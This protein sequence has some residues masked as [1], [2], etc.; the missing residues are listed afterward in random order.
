MG[1]IQIDFVVLMLFAFPFITKAEIYIVT[2]EGDPV[3]SYRGG[4][5]GF[6]ATAVESDEE[7]D[8]T[9]Y[10]L[11]LFLIIFSLT[12]ISYICL[13]EASKSKCYSTSTVLSPVYIVPF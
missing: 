13:L 8:V 11:V 12:D 2:V 5:D 1:K 7:L 9:R 3:I 10:M 6:S 4:I